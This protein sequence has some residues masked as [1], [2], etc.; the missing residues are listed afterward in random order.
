MD[1]IEHQIKAN[2]RQTDS[3]FIRN[4]NKSSFCKIYFSKI[5]RVRTKKKKKSLKIVGITVNHK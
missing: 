5:F 3:Y 4:K 2:F 1:T